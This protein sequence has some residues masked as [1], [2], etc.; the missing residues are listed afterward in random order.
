MKTQTRARILRLIERRQGRRPA[1]LADDLGITPQAIHR[2]L[3]DLVAAGVLEIRGRSPLTRYVLA[4]APELDKPRAWY[5][6]RTAPGQ[7]AGEFVCETRD[8]F[9][10]R[11]SRLTALAKAGLDPDDLPLVLSVAGEVG[12]NCFDHNLGRWRD[13]PGCW[14]ETQVTGRALWLCIADRGQGILRSLSRVLPEIRAE[15]DALSAA[16][17]RHVSGR[18]PENR[19]NG[20]KFV[21][22]IIRQGKSR[23]L[24]C[25]SGDGLV[26][27][28]ALGERCARELARWSPKAGGTATLVL[29]SFE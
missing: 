24:A 1:E 10:A 2:H 21:K 4:G 17:E 22:N 6:S 20:L 28:G 25:R 3:R 16:F 19:G 27:Y 23:G 13:I 15:Q 11:Q 26:H 9:A 12:N 14:L 8:A 5:G 29:W 7:G 18:A